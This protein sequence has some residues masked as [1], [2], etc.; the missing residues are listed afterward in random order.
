MQLSSLH[1]MASHVTGKLVSRA[2]IGSH[3]SELE[4]GMSL[5]LFKIPRGGLSGLAMSQTRTDQ[6]SEIDGRLNFR[7]AELGLGGEIWAQF[8][9]ELGE[10]NG[11]EALHAARLL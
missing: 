7:D 9:H 2:I 1:D 8:Q 6:P 5:S 3:E 11:K 4:M 10:Q